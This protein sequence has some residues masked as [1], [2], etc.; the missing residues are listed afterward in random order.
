VTTR[1]GLACDFSRLR[2]IDAYPTN[3]PVLVGRDDDNREP[4]AR[5]R[6]T[7]RRRV[8]RGVGVKGTLAKFV[9]VGV[10]VASAVGLPAS[11]AFARP[12]HGNGPLHSTFDPPETVQPVSGD[13]PF[14]DLPLPPFPN[15][16]L[17]LLWL[18]AA[19]ARREMED[20]L[21]P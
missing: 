18:A 11:A 13:V 21:F 4:A 12:S 9:V 3:L 14:L 20:V 16:P 10:L 17:S 2:S 1:D 5:Y 8:E 7:A 15:D 6:F 19:L